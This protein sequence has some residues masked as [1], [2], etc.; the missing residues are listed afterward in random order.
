MKHVTQYNVII[1][2]ESQDRYIFT[3]YDGKE[4][5]VNFNQGI[6]HLFNDLKT[7]HCPHVTELVRLLMINRYG[8]LE[9]ICKKTLN[10]GIELYMEVFNYPEETIKAL[11]PQ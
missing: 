10:D 11:M 9:H 2:D 5:K 4:F 3:S 7:K 8:T 1:K 6:D